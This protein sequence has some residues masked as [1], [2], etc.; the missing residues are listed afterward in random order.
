MIRRASLLAIVCVVA[1]LLV[2]PAAVGYDVPGKP[3]GSP[4]GPPT[5][6]KPQ[7]PAPKSTAGKDDVR[8]AERAAHALATALAGFTNA[9]L[10]AHPPFTV[11]VDVLIPGKLSC[12]VWTPPDLQLGAVTKRYDAVG[13]NEFEF[14]F[15][16][17]A[18]N[19]LKKAEGK[20]L[21]LAVVCAYRAKDAPHNENAE[22]RLKTLG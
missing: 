5:N 18:D 21:E 20:P 19:R 12:H 1:A 10:A 11:K 2:V 16:V 6:A 4:G 9:E 15:F 22:V 7:G 8:I 17:G 3:K 13:E 14:D